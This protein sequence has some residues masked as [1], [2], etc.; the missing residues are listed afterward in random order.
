MHAYTDRLVA[1]T[2]IKINDHCNEVKGSCIA[3]VQHNFLSEIICYCCQSK[4]D[5]PLQKS[6]SICTVLK[7]A[8][9]NMNDCVCMCHE[10]C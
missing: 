4:N 10:Y 7:D 5:Q 3:T 1:N 8:C 9:K 2:E 6:T